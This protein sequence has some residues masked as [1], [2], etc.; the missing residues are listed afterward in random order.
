MSEGKELAI[1]EEAPVV[2]LTEQ[3]ITT[4]AHNIQMAEKLVTTVLE[5]DVDYGIH[6]GTSSYALRD[7]GASKI[8]N[9]FNL[10]PQHTILFSR[11]D[12]EAISF[13]VQASLISRNT[14]QVV[15]IGIG[16][17]ST[18]ESKYAY[19]WVIKPEDFGYERE[20]LR[21]KNDKWRI[22][23]PDVE[24]LGNT[25]LKMAAKRSEIDACQNLPGVGSALRK[26]FGGQIGKHPQGQTT[27]PDY[28]KFYARAQG[29]GLGHDQVHRIL[30]ISSMKDWIAQGFTLEDAIVTL[31]KKL[32]ALA[33]QK[34]KQ[35]Q[36][37]Q[38]Q[39]KAQPEPT[40]KDLTPDDIT[41]DMVADWTSV[42]TLAKSFWGIEGNE[43]AKE[44]GYSNLLDLEFTTKPWDAFLQLRANLEQRQGADEQPPLTDADQWE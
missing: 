30:N 40:H 29:M 35:A 13:I 24:D 7:P 2:E 3:G 10:Y 16:G 25:I 20:G 37:T 43:L 1:K 6:P 11:E 19:R 4:V 23:N 22:P 36:A 31:A 17:C 34:V 9:A 32:T 42:Y 12:E 27:V 26:L 38:P 15:A 18:L 39:P 21:F 41:K 44:L 33:A 5:R 28:G 8:S 14:G